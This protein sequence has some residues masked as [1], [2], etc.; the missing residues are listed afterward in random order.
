L[1]CACLTVAMQRRMKRRHGLKE[2]IFDTPMDE[3][4][5]RI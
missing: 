4:L 5:S 2:I 3:I 1:E